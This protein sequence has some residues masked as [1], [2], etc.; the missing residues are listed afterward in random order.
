MNRNNPSHPNRAIKTAIIFACIIFAAIRTVFICSEFIKFSKQI[1]FEAQNPY[2]RYGIAVPDEFTRIFHYE[3]E[4]GF[5]GDKCEAEGYMADGNN[6]FFT[7]FSDGP[8]DGAEDLMDF[9]FDGAGVPEK[10]RPD[11]S[12]GYKWKIFEY[13]DD[14]LVILYFPDEGTVYFANAII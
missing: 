2:E 11:R 3:S 12:K 8:D 14:R 6:D 5:T 9:V 7:G 1:F 10:F 4:A 13:L